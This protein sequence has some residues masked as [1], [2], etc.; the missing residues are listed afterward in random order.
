MIL[1][2]NL[3]RIFVRS[4]SVYIPAYNSSK[5]NYYVHTQANVISVQDAVQACC[6]RSPLFPEPNIVR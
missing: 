3:R 6:D 2:A 1:H 4:I 5:H